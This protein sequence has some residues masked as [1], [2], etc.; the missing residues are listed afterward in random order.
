MGTPSPYNI[1]HYNNNLPSENIY[2]MGF[3][4]VDHIDAMLAYWDINQV[5]RFANNAY[6]QFFKKSRDE[7]VGIITL[8]EFNGTH[9]EE[10]IPLIKKVLKGKKQSF[11]RRMISASGISQDVI[12]KFYPDLSEGDTVGFFMH[13]EDITLIK[14]RQAKIL[15]VEKSK[16]RTILRSLIETQEIEREFIAHELR[17]NAVQTL[18]Y[19]KMTIANM[20]AGLAQNIHKVIDDLNELGVNL[21]PSII[22]M[23]GFCAGVEEYI[24]NFQNQHPVKI[25][26]ECPGA[27]DNLSINDKV[28]VF[29]IIQDY[30]LMFA[31]NPEKDVIIISVD[32]LP[33]KLSLRMIHNT[34]DFELS[35]SSKEFK[36]I[37]NRIE[38]Y[39]GSWQEFKNKKGMV[40]LINLKDV[41]AKNP[42]VQ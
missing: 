15:G 19:C 4:V 18:A 12:I 20:S 35:K 24:H 16:K 42:G 33:P 22:S 9:H 30:L 25:T 37:E 5:C 39:G 38:Y 14:K 10:I 40:F 36:D 32:Y 23:I 2:E 41:A 29:R 21:S 34:P 17:D 7:V 6:L 31:N 26:F 1:S 3:R 11:E 27:I 13:A 28:S 8:K